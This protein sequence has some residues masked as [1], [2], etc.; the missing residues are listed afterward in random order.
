V[1]LTFINNIQVS[2]PNSSDNFFLPK[3][4][5]TGPEICEPFLTQFLGS[6][7]KIKR[8]RDD[9]NACIEFIEI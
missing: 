3:H 4:I 9:S 7:H 1:I 6:I 2:G 8:N 5:R